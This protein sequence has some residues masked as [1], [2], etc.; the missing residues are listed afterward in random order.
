MLACRVPREK[1]PLQKVK[2]AKSYSAYRLIGGVY[3]YLGSTKTTT[4]VD[5]FK[6]GN[7]ETG[8][9]YS[10]KLAV[11]RGD[12]TSALSAAKSITVNK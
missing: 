5:M 2:D 6:K 11:K 1:I 12:R 3:T 7:Y 10:Y 9:T 8:V 4:Y